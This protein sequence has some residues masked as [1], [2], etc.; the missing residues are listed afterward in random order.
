MPSVV[1]KTSPDEDRY[2]VWSTVTESPH[3]YGSRAEMADLLRAGIRGGDPGDRRNPEPV[4][5]RV[6]EHGSSDFAGCWGWDDDEFVYKRAGWLRRQDLWAAAQLQCD[7]RE[8]D[9]L[10]LLQ[11]LED[12]E[13]DRARLAEVKAKV[14]NG[15]GPT[16]LRYAKD[17]IGMTAAA[18][19]AVAGAVEGLNEAR[20]R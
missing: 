1:I 16:G 20:E 10:D 18:L 17:E 6:D 9:L 8:R 7:R 12:D 19:S 11:P 3:A 2:V 15:D 5:A 4:L 14:S 13:E